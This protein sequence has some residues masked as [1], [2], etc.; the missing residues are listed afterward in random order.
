MSVLQC[1]LAQHGESLFEM[2]FREIQNVIAP[3]PAGPAWE[4]VI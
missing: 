3:I 1:R 4:I 2:D